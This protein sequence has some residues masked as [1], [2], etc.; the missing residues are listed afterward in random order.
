M[1]GTESKDSLVNEIMSMERSAMTKALLR[2]RG[3]VKM[4]FTAD[5]LRRQPTEWI[6]H[7]LLAAS[8]HCR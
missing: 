6:R 3:R 2:F 7:I 4:D 5:F 1:T 8:L